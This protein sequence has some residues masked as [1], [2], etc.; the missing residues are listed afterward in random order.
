MLT[1]G[2]TFEYKFI[3]CI[4]LDSRIFSALFW[5][6][7]FLPFLEYTTVATTVARHRARRTDIDIAI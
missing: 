1:C 4:S 6:G 2:P 7:W 5:N 3:D